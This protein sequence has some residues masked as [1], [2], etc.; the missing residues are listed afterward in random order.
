MLPVLWITW[1]VAVALYFGFFQRVFADSTLRLVL[2]VLSGILA[3]A[4]AALTIYCITANVEDDVVIKANKPRNVDYI[5]ISG[6][7]VI[8]PSTLFFN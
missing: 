7:P 5:K 4:Q 3:A 8:D 1:I 6:I 2:E